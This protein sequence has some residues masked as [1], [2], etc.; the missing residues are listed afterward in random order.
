[1]KVSAP[2]QVLERWVRRIEIEVSSTTRRIAIEREWDRGDSSVRLPCSF[3][4]AE[5]HRRHG[6]TVSGS[7]RGALPESTSSSP[8]T[9]EAR[10]GSFPPDPSS[11]GGCQQEEGVQNS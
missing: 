1:M 5:S 2:A 10:S 8:L 7:I 3:S 9:I 11:S 4:S 6:V